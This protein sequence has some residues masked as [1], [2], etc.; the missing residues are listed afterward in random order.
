MNTSLFH[1]SFSDLIGLIAAL[2]FPSVIDRLLRQTDGNLYVLNLVNRLG[3]ISD[4]EQIRVASNTTVMADVAGLALNPDGSWTDPRG[5][6]RNQHAL[7]EPLTGAIFDV[8]VEVFQDVLVARGLIHPDADAR[9]WTRAEVTAS[10]AGVHGA[11]A[12]AYAR[13]SAGFH[14]AVTIA[15]DVVGRAMAHAILTLRPATLSFPRVAARM[16]EAAAELGLGAKLPVLLDHFLWRGIDPR[17]FLT[18]AVVPGGRGRRR[19]GRRVLRAR[20]PGPGCA[21]THPDA[22]VLAGRLIRHPHREAHAMP[23]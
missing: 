22:F 15:R 3:K 16:L 17:P 6:N 20:D 10:L 11:S 7:G 2:H 23:P 5:E 13:F 21:C 12:R 18:M 9:G 19:H 1:E 14:Q 4:R 8:L